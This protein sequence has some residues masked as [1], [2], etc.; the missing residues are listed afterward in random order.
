M[1]R[2]GERLLASRSGSPSR[3]GWLA[4]DEAKPL[5]AD[6]DA[7]DLVEDF[8]DTAGHYEVIQGEYRGPR[9]D[10]DHVGTDPAALRCRTSAGLSDGL[11]S[12]R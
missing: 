11:N 10:A 6:P 3:T 2:G 5:A 7:A 8:A 12:V 1:T 4:E 9:V